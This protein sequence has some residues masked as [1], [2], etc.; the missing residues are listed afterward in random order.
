MLFITPAKG[1][2]EA[3]DY[4]T[5]HMA[6]SDYYLRDATECAGHW[7][8][9]GA[10]LLGLSGTVDKESYFKLC[11]NINPKTGE[12]LTPI[13]RGERR[14]L[15]DFTFDVSKSV[16]LAYELGGDERIMDALRSAV[17]DTMSEMEGAMMTRV[18]S[19]GR[20]EDRPSANMIWGE[21]IHHTSRPLEDGTC[22]P[23]LHIHA[24]VF[25]AS[26]DSQEQRWKAAQFTNLVR[27]KG[28][29][30]AAFHNRFAERLA[31]LGYGIE[32]DGNSFRLAG[33][34]PSI[35][36]K[37]SR[38]TE[39][40]EAEAERL[41]ITDAKAKGR[42]GAKTREKKNEVQQS[43]AELREEW[44][45]RLT[46]EEQDAICGAQRGQK[47]TSLDA[48]Q[49]MDYALLHCF[50]RG[51]AIP[52]KKLLQTALIQG[53]GASS[54]DEIKGEMARDNVLR[55]E[56]LGQRWVTTQE[57]L[58][59]EIGMTDFARDG[60]CRH[61]KLGGERKM[62]SLD[63]K[64]SKEQREAV[65]VI[66]NS[67][68][69]VTALKGDAGTGKTT[70]LQ[71]TV[72]AIE[73][74]GKKVFIFAP[75]AEAC[76]VLSGEGFENARTV[77]RLLID[78]KVQEEAKGQVLLVDEAGLLSVKDMKRLFDVA[79]DQQA[80]IVLSGD[81]KQHA[82]VYRGD[83][84]RILEKDSGLRTARLSEI[85]RQTDKPYRDAVK[86][87]SEGD[88]VGKHGKTRLEAGF[89]ML[90]NMGAIVEN[91]GDDRHRQIAVDYAAITSQRK[92]NRFKSALVVS[93][94]HAEGEKVTQAVRDELKTLGRLAKEERTFLSLRS[95][96]LTEAQRSDAREYSPGAVVQFHQNAK[97]FRSS[98]RVT[99][100][101]SKDG[102]V[103]IRRT[104]GTDSFLPLQEAKK[105]QLYS[106]GEVALSVGDT[107]RTTQNGFA[108]DSRK[109]LAGKGARKD[110]NNGRIYE[111]AGFTRE[112]DIRLGNGYILPK[113]YGGLTHG[114]V[115]TSH[116]SQGKTC[117]VALVAVGPES[118]AAANRE[119]FYV[120][121]SRGR[122]AVRLYTDDKEAVRSAIQSSGAR[123]SATEMM[124][125]VKS[126]SKPKRGLK[127]RLFTLHRAYRIYKDRLVQLA[128]RDSINRQR[129]GRGLE[130]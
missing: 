129:E 119:Q 10:E 60:K 2:K 70:M 24:V 93:P 31:H 23:Q 122:E 109:G 115:V 130:R 17:K 34:D 3:K 108:K 98:E 112:G 21:F 107:I 41:G 92:G 103:S 111:V 18:R 47:T 84:L 102:K 124:E 105:F 44:S 56:R 126:I 85:W 25:N 69:T 121:V 113:N 96:N 26:Y 38:R 77:E 43:M 120:S 36:E 75:S 66:L 79:K 68:D 127:E 104:D 61:S 110:I 49:A 90:D 63:P 117:D 40:I 6:V 22:D 81:S 101:G 83:A 94:T 53:V 125:G 58:R 73:S 76:S 42:L 82:G 57:V 39:I 99:V 86:A 116:A 78:P 51:S 28:Y 114:Y 5:R 95:L 89:D 67:R 46:D 11:D 62:L 30:Q 80:R 64:L 118:L 48:G 9:L 106:A 37:F 97:G 128:M 29:Y 1:S 72:R 8:G 35:A 14:V 4:F 16:T 100:T 20:N 45:A 74:S 52:E 65:A 123:L 15:Y 50:E 91:P 13:T 32:R 55:R 7:H 33:I 27:D 54:V 88:V 12:Q 59:E 71:D 87:I 19:N